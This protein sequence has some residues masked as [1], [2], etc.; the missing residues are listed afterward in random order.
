MQSVTFTGY[1]GMNDFEAWIGDCHLRETDGGEYRCQ[2]AV[3][4]NDADAFRTRLAAHVET[5]GY[6]L[7]WVEECH[8]APQYLQRHGGEL[9]YVGPLARTVH[10]GHHV[11]LSRLVAVGA[12]GGSDSGSHLKFEEIEGVE[13]LGFQVGV[14]EAQTVPEALQKP[15]FGQPAPTEAEIAQYGGVDGV[16]AMKVYAILDAGKVAHLCTS[17]EDFNCAYECLFQGAAEKEMRDAAPYIVELGPH[18]GFTRHV[19]S[20]SGMPRDIW[21]KEA[22]IFIRSRMSI[23]DLRKHF[24]RFTRI[25]VE[26]DKRWIYFRF[27]EPTMIPYFLRGAEKDSLEAF[28][29][30]EFEL[31]TIDDAGKWQRI[32]LCNR[33]SEIRSKTI[34]MKEQDFKSFKIYV[35][36]RYYYQLKNW[37][38]ESFGNPCHIEDID[39]F[40][41]SEV[42][43][44]INTFR[45]GDKRIIAHYATASWLLGER[46]WESDQ[47]NRR[48]KIKANSRGARTLYERAHKCRHREIEA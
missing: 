37:I 36:M 43:F 44:A 14:D 3:W 46:A 9:R 31:H 1:F 25:Q 7:V 5:Q 16:P 18:D 11:E 17:M 20:A 48:R 45:T 33:P 4:T 24:R 6:S 32:T 13:P 26:A 8:P 19:F 39:G 29:S 2:A 23:F 30:C 22:G 12:E 35:H 41:R 28:F 34:T 40:L 21:G 10:P 38:I 42:Q 15:L 47:V 27:W